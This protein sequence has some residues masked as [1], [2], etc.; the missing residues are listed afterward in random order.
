LLETGGNS[1][2]ATELRKQLANLHTQGQNNPVVKQLRSS[3]QQARMSGAAP[4]IIASLKNQIKD[5][6]SKHLTDISE[7]TQ[8]IKQQLSDLRSNYN[9]H[10]DPRVNTNIQQIGYGRNLNTTGSQ[11][12]V[13][14]SGGEGIAQLV[15]DPK[16]N[17]LSVLKTHDPTAT[18]YNPALIANKDKLIGQTLPNV[19]TTYEKTT[20]RGT[21]AG[22]AIPQYMSEYVPGSQMSEAQFEKLQPNL[23][24]TIN[25]AVNQK[26]PGIELS[27]L[28]RTN[29]KM[30]P[31]GPKAIDYMAVDSKDM[32]PMA[33]R[34]RANYVHEN[35]DMSSPTGQAFNFEDPHNLANKVLPEQSKRRLYQLA[36]GNSLQAQNVLNR[37]T[38]HYNNA[39]LNQTYGGTAP[40][41]R[42]TPQQINQMMQ[43]KNTLNVTPQQSTTVQRP[44]SQQTPQQ[45]ITVPQPKTQQA[46]QQST[47]VQRP[48]KTSIPLAQA[49]TQIQTQPLLSKINPFAQTIIQR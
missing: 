46:L 8:N 24:Q 29:F 47:T 13:L 44:K 15:A 22:R 3:L 6:A 27:D 20:P 40:L 7:K 11:V 16:R 30:T 14:G 37:A 48:Q 26:I 19:A 23:N 9:P 45:N 49:A 2:L 34:R 17:Q 1:P 43:S 32:L 33:Q 35:I 28:N 38:Q 25:Q 5:T 39:L 10:L 18:G 4:D 36:E 12:K 31:T 42:L 41:K 21:I